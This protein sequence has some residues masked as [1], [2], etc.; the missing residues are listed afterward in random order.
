[1]GQTYMLTESE[2]LWEKELP[3]GVEAL[4]AA[5]HGD[6]RGTDIGVQSSSSP[7]AGVPQRD[8]TRTITYQVPHNAAMQVYDYRERRAQ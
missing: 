6:I 3:P 8:C 7:D 5:A 2:E 1:M 4:L